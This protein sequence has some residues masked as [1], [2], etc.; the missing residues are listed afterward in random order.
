[1]RLFLGVDGGQSATVA[2]IGDESGQVLGVGRAGPCNH[3][4]L[5]EGRERFLTA[6]DGSVGSALHGA[7]LGKTI[8]ESACFGFSGGPEDKASLTRQRVQAARYTITHD[9]EIALA[10]ATGGEP[11]EIVIAGTGSIA[12][13]RN[14]DGKSARAGGWGYLFGDEGSAFDL[15]RQSLRAALRHAEGW[16][17][18]TALTSLLLDAASAA[19]AHDLL[20]RFYSDE[21][22]RDRIAAMA[23]LVD[24]AAIAGDAIAQEI[25]KAA[26]QSL[27]ALLVTIR[28]QLFVPSESTIASFSGGVFRSHILRERFRL[29]VELDGITRLI[30]PRFSSAAGALIQA[31]RAVGLACLPQQIPEEKGAI[32]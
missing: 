28:A 30:A 31:Y 18:S 8:F 5:A 15:V 19:S 29:L 25:L 26:A 21:F 9:A 16:G 17:P 1:M 14:A 20:H 24:Q 32:S 13:G 12:Y 3:A 2:L 11:G 27:A 10:G 7:G 6:L 4:T 22:P 23:P